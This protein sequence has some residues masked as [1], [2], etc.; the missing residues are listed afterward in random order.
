MVKAVQDWKGNNNIFPILIIYSSSFM[1]VI[2][3]PLS[4]KPTFSVQVTFFSS[5]DPCVEV[6]VK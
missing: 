5:D 3:V 6:H 2:L 4:S 1:F